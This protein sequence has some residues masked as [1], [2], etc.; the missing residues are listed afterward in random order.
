MFINLKFKT[1]QIVLAVLY[2]IIIPLSV[3]AFSISPPILE[4]EANPGETVRTNIRVQ[5]TSDANKIYAF[6]IQKFISKGGL[7]QQEFL[8]PTETDGLPE[9]L[10]FDRPLL[11]LEP[12]ESY[13]LPIVLRVPMDAKSGGHFVAVLFAEQAE[14]SRGAV[15]IVPRTGTLIFLTVRG[16]VLKSFEIESFLSSPVSPSHLPIDFS[17]NLS[18][19]GNVHIRPEGRLRITNMFGN[20]VASYPLNPSGA[21]ILPASRRSFQ[22]AWENKDTLKKGYFS[23][24]REEFRNF[25]FGKYS[26]ELTIKVGTIERTVVHELWIWPW[27][28]I[29]FSGVLLVAVLSIFVMR[30]RMIS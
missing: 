1:I 5:N 18:N 17:A 13:D 29:V 11:E 25:G 4:F 16:N 12:G 24:L 27:R 7:G 22:I 30:K 2:F 8:P 26:A 28:I 21:R 3:D 10:Y 23:E 20:T 15:G 9:W 14:L 19:T 6:T